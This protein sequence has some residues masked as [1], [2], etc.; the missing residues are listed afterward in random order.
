MSLKRLSL[1]GLLLCSPVHAADLLEV[2]QEAIRTNPQLAAARSSLAAVREQR[3]QA[4]A[5]LLPSLDASGTIRRSRFQDVGPSGPARYSTDKLASLNLTQPVFRYDRWIGLNRSDSEI[6]RAEA[7]YIA[8]QQDLM[9][10]VTERYFKVLDAQDNLEFAEAEKK[11]IG[12]Q[13]DQATQRFD[14]GLIAITDVKAAQARYDLSVSQEI[15]AISTLVAAKDDLREVTGTYYEHVNLLKA[16]LDLSNPEPNSPDAWIKQAKQHNLSILAARANTETARQDIRL[17][18]AGH[19]PTLDL[20]ASTSFRDVNFGG[21]FPQK[22]HDTDI[23]FQLN[24]PLYQG[25]AVNSRTRQ[26]RN[27]F[28]ESTDRLQQ[29]V[30]SVELETRN[31]FRGVKT[32]IAQVKALGRSLESTEVAVEAEEAGFE[33]GTRTIVDV[34]N[35]Q[36]EYFLARLNYARARYLYVVDQLRLK[37]ASGILTADDLEEL[38]QALIPPSQNISSPQTP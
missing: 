16:D 9:I 29:Q 23:G 28:Q 24:I 3:P 18:R 38:N 30:R 21:T 5:Q 1:I 17:Q 2:Y 35:A 11:A 25:G 20:T 36:R 10:L 27:R 7:D 26:A 22:R 33:V 12:R 32:D 19:L 14:V 15:Q 34:L 37:K 4:L 13:L 31:A 8:A 6:I